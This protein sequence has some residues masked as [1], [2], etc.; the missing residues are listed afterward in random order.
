MVQRNEIVEIFMK[1]SNDQNWNN[2]YE[3]KSMRGTDMEQKK[4][5]IQAML[6]FKDSTKIA[7]GINFHELIIHANHGLPQVEPISLAL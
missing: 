3:F 7:A 1:E 6:Y 4:A 2:S 5:M